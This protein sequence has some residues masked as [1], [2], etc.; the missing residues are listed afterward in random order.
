MSYLGLFHAVIG[1]VAVV[2]GAVVL[3]NKKG[4]PRHKRLGRIWVV[5]MLL[6]N[7][8][9]LSI[10]NLFGGFGP[11]HWAA[12]ASLSA[13][14]AGFY[15]A[16]V[17]PEGW[18]V[19]HEFYMSWSYVGLLAATGAEI[20]S[21]VPGWNF[22]WSVSLTVIAIVLVGGWRLGWRVPSEYHA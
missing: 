9:A 7:V 19:R 6:L 11:F 8:S 1:T 21:R 16:L 10:Y 12:L 22:F 3:F 5:A 13:L 18:R 15:P 20:T 14:A 4:T 2:M 17:R